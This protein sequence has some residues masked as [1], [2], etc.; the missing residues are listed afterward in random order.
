LFRGELGRRRFSATADT[1]AEIDTI[2]HDKI[3]TPQAKQQERTLIFW[4]I[5]TNTI[6]TKVKT[7]LPVNL[8]H[9]QVYVIRKVSEPHLRLRLHFCQHPILR[10]AEV[11]A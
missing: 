9:R 4:A 3:Y 8:C 5:L 1:L 7:G 2:Q 10:L 11:V 6:L